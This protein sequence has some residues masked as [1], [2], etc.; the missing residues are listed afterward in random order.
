M[1]RPSITS[2]G[3]RCR[4]LLTVNLAKLFRGPGTLAN[5]VSLYSAAGELRVMNAARN[6]ALLSPHD[7]KTNE[8][9]LLLE[10]PR[11]RPGAQD[12]HGAHGGAARRR[13][14]GVSGRQDAEDGD[15][16]GAREVL[17]LRREPAGARDI[18]APLGRCCAYGGRRE[19][20]P[21]CARWLSA[22]I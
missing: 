17:H 14:L 21:T 16:A 9:G 18:A 13:H 15:G 8:L 5:G 11:D 6:S 10:E 7:T 3:Y 12:R 20:H 1:R 2:Q 22:L 4:R 19:G